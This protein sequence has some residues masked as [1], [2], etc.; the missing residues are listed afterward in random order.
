VFEEVRTPALGGDV[1]S[2][3][4]NGHWLPLGLTVDDL[5]GLVLTVDELSGE[6]AQTLQDWLAPI[7]EQVGAELLVTDDAEGFKTVAEELGLGATIV[8]V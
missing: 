3:K 2:V 6:D 5:T 8:R 1:T 4:C 7:A